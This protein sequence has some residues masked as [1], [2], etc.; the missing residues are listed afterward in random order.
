VDGSPY[1]TLHD[2]VVQGGKTDCEDRLGIE[3]RLAWVLDGATPLPD[4][5]T[6]AAGSDAVWLVDTLSAGLRA[7]A[8][9]GLGGSETLN[10][11]LEEALS[12][13]CSAAERELAGQPEVP[14]SAAIGLLWNHPDNVEYC[15]LADVTVHF[16][17]PARTHTDR[18]VDRANERVAARFRRLLA[19]TGSYDR[20]FNAVRRELRSTRL[21]L[22][23][24]PGGYWV[25]SVLPEAAKQSI[26]GYQD[27]RAAGRV[28]CCTDGFSRL[29]DT[30]G[31]YG[32][33]GE[34]LSSPRPLSEL[35]ADLRRHE[36]SD[37]ECVQFPRWS[38]H[39]DAAAM[40]LEP[41]L[42]H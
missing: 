2:A 21:T 17:G 25:A 38:V 35:V 26:H 28:L 5:S 3:G 16:S 30:F 40:V 20:S 36:D 27:R 4:V 37:P 7:L 8:V 6:S 39:D 31:L 41:V 15:L 10:D 18:R 13:V 29:W 24:K 11:L 42:R 1:W 19:K 12:S 9:R 22:M 23:N 34:V 14:P 32:S 33:A